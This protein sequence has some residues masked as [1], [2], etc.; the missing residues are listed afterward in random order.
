MHRKHSI[1][2]LNAFWF[3]PFLFVC[4][5][6]MWIKFTAIYRKSHCCLTRYLNISF[7]FSTLKNHRRIVCQPFFF[8]FYYY[9][10]ILMDCVRLE[11]QQRA[12][13]LLLHTRTSHTY[14]LCVCVYS[15]WFVDAVWSRNFRMVL[16][17]GVIVCVL[18]LF[19]I[20]SCTAAIFSPLPNVDVI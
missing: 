19:G 17:V 13:K 4:C 8:I 5:K 3:V 10:S 7:V 18:R 16:F 9:D 2:L 12:V 6:C 1:H 20:F 15:L 11:R 14:R